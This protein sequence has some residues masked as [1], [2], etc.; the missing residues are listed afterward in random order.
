MPGSPVDEPA[1]RRL[2]P[3]IASAVALALAGAAH[4]EPPS[5]IAE[6]RAALANGTSCETV[7]SETLERIAEVEQGPRRPR[8][9]LGT[10]SGSPM[11]S[12]RSAR[13]ESRRAPCTA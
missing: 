4:A 3:F 1:V 8:A 2:L 11:R 13:A 12:T 7:V 9:V 6:L 10:R 5:S